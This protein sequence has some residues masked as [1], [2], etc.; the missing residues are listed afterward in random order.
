[1]YYQDQTFRHAACRNNPGYRAFLQKVL[2]LGIED[3][4]LD[5]IEFDQLQWWQE[6][7]SCHCKYC[8]EGSGP[9]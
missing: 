9:S 7:G 1:M 5:M 4:K 8:Q 6:P 2:R 3:L